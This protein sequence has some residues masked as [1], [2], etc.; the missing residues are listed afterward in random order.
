MFLKNSSQNFRTIK[1][2]QMRQ[3][4]HAACTAEKRNDERLRWEKLET[5]SKKHTEL[6]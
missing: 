6:Y 3:A 1:S 4:G 2:R 5:R